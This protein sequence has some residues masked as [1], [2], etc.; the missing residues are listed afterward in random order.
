MKGTSSARGAVRHRK[1]GSSSN[2]VRRDGS[3]SIGTNS[4]VAAPQATRLTD[5]ES[6]MRRGVTRRECQSHAGRRLGLEFALREN[7]PRVHADGE[8]GLCLT[9]RVPRETSQPSGHD[10]TCTA[11]TGQSNTTS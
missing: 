4:L 5:L 7:V 11:A 9:L 8:A 3:L 6:V 2:A 10:L 1:R